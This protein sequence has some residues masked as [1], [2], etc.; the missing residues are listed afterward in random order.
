MALIVAALL[1]SPAAA[2]SLQV[3]HDRSA[4]DF[5]RI[6]TTTCSFPIT[7]HFTANVD[8]ALFFDSNGNLVRVLETVDHAE[9]TYTAN[10]KTLTARGSGGFDLRFNADGSR[11]VA[12]FGIN[13]LLTLPGQGAVFLDVGRAEFLFDPHIHVLFQAGPAD[14]DI[15]AFCAALA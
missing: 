2:D 3:V 9:I 15:A 10:G 4:N 5:T 7:T 12:T 1:A 14:Y 11:T 8:D 13:L 6:D